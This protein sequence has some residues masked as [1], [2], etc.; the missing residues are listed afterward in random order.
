[1]SSE[2]CRVR[3]RMALYA[4]MLVLH[5]KSDIRARGFV[6]QREVMYV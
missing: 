5:K 4:V 2:V 3:H 6:Y 1:M